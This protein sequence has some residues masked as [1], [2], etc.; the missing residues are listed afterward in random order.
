[1]AK[2]SDLVSGEYGNTD[3]L[4]ELRALG[5][6]GMSEGGDPGQ[7][8]RDWMLRQKESGLNTDQIGTMLLR[9]AQRGYQGGANPA[10]YYSNNN[11]VAAKEALRQ[12][13][14]IDDRKSYP[15]QQGVFS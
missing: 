9:M 12:I 3:I 5:N 13:L 11:R 8:L 2:Q 1:M 15:S 4:N 7:H 14:G 6:P 10:G